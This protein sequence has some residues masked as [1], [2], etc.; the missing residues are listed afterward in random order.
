MALPRILIAGLGSIGSLVAAYIHRHCELYAIGRKWHVDAIK[1]RGF[2]ILRKNGE[3]RK[4]ILKNVTTTM[5][6]LPKEFDFIIVTTKAH[7]TERILKELKEAGISAKCYVLL[8]NGIGNEEVVYKV[9]GQVNLIRG[10]T[11]NGANIPEPGVVIHAGIGETFFAPVSGSNSERFA[12]K[13]VELFNESGLPAKLEPNLVLLIWK[14]VI[15]NAVI[16]SLTAVLRMKNRGV[17]LSNSARKLAEM[18]IEEICKIAARKGIQ[19]DPKEMINI[20]MKVA[21]NTGENISSTLQDVLRGKKTEMDFICGAIVREAKKMKIN[22]PICE[23][24]YYLIKI[25]EEL[26]DKGV[27][28]KASSY[29]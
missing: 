15:I 24:L 19:I 5:S 9:L 28:V 16:N 21:K 10:I 23:T 17:Y 27:F 29:S 14:K 1:Q 6:N 8:Q 26:H 2:L 11:N 13:L 7:D 20:V 3:E 4:I 25:I 12:R 22:V 18:I